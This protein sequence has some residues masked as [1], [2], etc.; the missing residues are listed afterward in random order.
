MNRKAYIAL[1]IACRQARDLIA[2]E[3]D[4]MVQS[5]SIGASGKRSALS[6][7][8]EREIA[9]WEDVLTKIDEALGLV[10]EADG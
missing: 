4:S 6:A 3:R 2:E 8:G 10:K 9:P 1:E 7:E 5:Y